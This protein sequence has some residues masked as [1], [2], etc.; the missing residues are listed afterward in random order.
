MTDGN[1][2]Q[3][4]QLQWVSPIVQTVLFLILPFS[5]PEAK[6]F[7]NNFVVRAWKVG[8]LLYNIPCVRMAGQAQIFIPRPLRL[9]IWFRFAPWSE[10]LWVLM[11]ERSGRLTTHY[12]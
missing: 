2:P 8:I 11:A 4:P 9:K 10:S 1:C 3:L 6:S 5:G 7:L 12:K